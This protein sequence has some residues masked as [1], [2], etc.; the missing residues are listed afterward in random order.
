MKDTRNEAHTQQQLTGGEASELAL[1]GSDGIDRRNS[2]SCTACADTRLLWT[3]A[4][5][6][7]VQVSDSHIGFNEAAKQDL[8]GRLRLALDKGNRLPV[9]PDLP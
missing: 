1:A 9:A 8:I 7:F 4:G 3:G 6:S 2:L 5:F